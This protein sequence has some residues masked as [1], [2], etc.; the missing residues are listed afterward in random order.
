MNKHSGQNGSEQLPTDEKPTR[1]GKGR[2]V[3]K[4]LLWTVGILVGLPV[5][6]A[7]VLLA[8]ALIFRS[9]PSAHMPEGFSAYATLPSAS[10]FVSEALHLKALDAALSD[11]ASASLRGT[12]R[13]MRANPFL[14]S[15][16]FKRLANIRVDIAAYDKGFVLAADLGLRSALT[17]LAH[18]L[19]RMAPGL[20][21]KVA[22]L[23]YQAEESPPRFVYESDGIRMYALVYRNVLI[24]SSDPGLLAM[25]ARPS[26]L[27]GERALAK[28]LS[29]PGKASLRFLADT[30]KL[31]AGMGSESGNP[32][33]SILQA[34]SFPSLS[35]VDLGLSDQ[36]IS[37]NVQL[38][39]SSSDTGL[40]ELLGK[41]ARTPSFL[42]RLPESAEYFSLLSLA[43]P[44]VLWETLAPFLGHSTQST[45]DTA[46]SAA[47]AAFGME[48][49]TM[50]FSWMGEELGIMGSATGP[51]PVFF[52]SIADERA[53]KTVFEKAFDSILVG[54]DISAMVN[55]VRVP[56][57]IFPRWLSGFLEKLGV[58]LV[59]PYYLVE[60]GFLWLSS[61]AETLA[62]CVAESRSGRLLVKTERWKTVSKD[63]S[64]EASAIVYYSLDRSV[65]FFLRSSGGITKALQLYR[66]GVAVLRS[67][68]D[69]LSLSLSAV[70]VPGT[71]AAELPGFPAKAPSRMDSDPVLTRGE[72]GAPMA[73][74]T[75]GKTVLAMDLSSG[76]TERLELDDTAMFAAQLSN[77]AVVSLWAVSASGTIYRC[78]EN[79]KSLAGFPLVSG[80]A[81]SAWPAVSGSTLVVP[82]SG[83]N[84][85]MLVDPDG[86]IR[87]SAAMHA[88]ARSAAA[89]TETL[90]A[91]LPRSFDAQLYLFDAQ[92]EL[93]P[94][95][96][97][98]L[99]SLASAP[100]V[101]ASTARD[102]FVAAITEAGEFSLWNVDGQSADGFPVSLYGTFTAAPVW[103]SGLR[104][105]YAL[106]TEGTLWHIA[107]NGSVLGSVPLPRGPAR[108]GMLAAL[109]SDGDGLEELY[110]SGGG[111]A[112]YAYSHDLALL[113]G[114]PVPGMGL[115]SFIDIDGD[116]HLDMVSRGADDS[117]HAR[118][119]GDR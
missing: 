12:V 110:V 80:Q 107:A 106:S 24:A 86:N 46:N 1:H 51:A 53:R 63:I 109:D 81:V 113:Q 114:F 119:G 10:G 8:T 4:A 92:G 74:W 29:A 7:L 112:L 76:A 105:W 36:R 41:R 11:P 67:G 85:L 22:G 25:A 98:A 118:E 17:R 40:S 2:R 89:V 97:V 88:R 111:D 31:K 6:M 28:A 90:I 61:S 27:E 34:L 96:P 75:S 43:K 82:V 73:Y 52:V 64:P 95:W 32:L 100:A 99:S 69:G 48:I 57:I 79:L 3:A 94:G 38:P 104:S 15:S 65:P 47:K 37:L 30:Q 21:K 103:A 93:K 9:D 83:N 33:G 101:I 108:D 20:L 72:N 116:G 70:N 39:W 87:Y 77:G 91:A 78:D 58:K 44:N 66:R 68:K 115:P 14:R 50:L 71:S 117:I 55:G 49:Q 62:S 13:S 42:S 19:A 18:P 56:R 102:N 54:R 23:S 84:A 60:D 26:R 5:V 16:L 35:V 45:Y 59:E